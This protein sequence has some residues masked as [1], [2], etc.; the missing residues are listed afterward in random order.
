MSRF[1]AVWTYNLLKYVVKDSNGV[2]AKN[3]DGKVM[4]W[5]DYDTAAAYAAKLN[6]ERKRERG[7]P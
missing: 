6:G 5:R 7:E 3:P 2:H 1:R 4:Q